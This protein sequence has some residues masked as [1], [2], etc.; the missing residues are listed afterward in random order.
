MTAWLAA[1]IALLVLAVP[2]GFLSASGSMHSRVIGMQLSSTI[3]TLSLVVLAEAFNRDVYF[4]LAIVTGA[5][6]LVGT[7]VYVRVLD[8]WL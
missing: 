2:A 5:L 6:S 8:S 3:V 7:F 1:A 4:D